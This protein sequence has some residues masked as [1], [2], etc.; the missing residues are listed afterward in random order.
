MK[1]LLHGLVII[2]I[3]LVISCDIFPPQSSETNYFPLQVGNEWHYYS[4]GANTFFSDSTISRIDSTYILNDK[5][6][7]VMNTYEPI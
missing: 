2:I 5:T 4:P 7:Y 6:Y 3:L 1:K